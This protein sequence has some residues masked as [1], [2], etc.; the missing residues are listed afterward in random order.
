MMACLCCFGVDDTMYKISAKKLSFRRF[1]LQHLLDILMIF[2]QRL[3]T[4]LMLQYLIKDP[5]SLGLPLDSVINGALDKR[6]SL[7]FQD[8]FSKLRFNMMLIPACNCSKRQASLLETFRSASELSAIE[9]RCRSVSAEDT[10]CGLKLL[11]HR[12]QL[13]TTQ[14]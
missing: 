13:M 2:N 9:M 10:G 5:S 7:R 14:G 11:C 3:T 12:L 6:P 4:I 8:H 1:A